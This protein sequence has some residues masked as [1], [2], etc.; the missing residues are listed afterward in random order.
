MNEET[1]SQKKIKKINPLEFEQTQSNN[2]C[3]E[4]SQI[5]RTQP[6]T[7]V[8]ELTKRKR[9]RPKKTNYG[10]T[11]NTKKIK[12]AK[13]IKVYTYGETGRDEDTEESD[14]SCDENTIND[15]QE[16]QV[17]DE[18]E[19][20]IESLDGDEVNERKKLVNNVDEQN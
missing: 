6:K 5:K 13:G 9:G 2:P 14:G 16:N 20:D 17:D 1:R 18:N 15:V 11:K 12:L 7:Q 19:D 3:A 4:S 8:S 10:K